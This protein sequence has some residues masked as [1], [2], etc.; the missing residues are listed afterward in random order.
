MLKMPVSSKPMRGSAARLRLGAQA[1][2]LTAK[3]PGSARWAST[4]ERATVNPVPK[5]IQSQTLHEIL[6][7]VSKTPDGVVELDLDLTTLLP[8]TRVHACLR[9]IHRSHPEIVE[10]ANP[11]KLPLIPGYTDE[12]IAAYPAQSGLQAKYPGL[13]LGKL[14][15]ANLRQPYWS[16]AP[17]ET[18]TLAPG[19]LRFIAK[20]RARKREVVFVSNRPGGAA[21]RERSLATL[22]AQGVTNIKLPLTPGGA[23]ADAKRALQ[24]VIARDY[25]KVVAII[26]DRATNRA[27]VVGATG[28]D[29]M[30]VAIAAPR[31]SWTPDAEQNQFRISTFE[32]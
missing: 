7:R 19:L 29:T 21:A 3:A 1:T 2:P 4:V 25:G 16:S 17:W 32:F 11:E 15:H 5:S 6:E 31:F 22:S 9:N 14:I 26:D 24:T 10:F 8:Y 12:A 23:D 18:D 27:A 28:N 30:S 20:V 13:D